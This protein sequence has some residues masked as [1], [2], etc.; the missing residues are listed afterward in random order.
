LSLGAS[1]LASTT[2]FSILPVNLFLR[3]RRPD[4]G[5]LSAASVRRIVAVLAA[6]HSVQT[7]NDVATPAN[8][9]ATRLPLRSRMSSTEIEQFRLDLWG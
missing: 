4:P 1:D 8:D 7:T 6:T 3:L 2:T 5:P 9:T